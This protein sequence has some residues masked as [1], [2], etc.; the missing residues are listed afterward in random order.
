[1]DPKDCYILLKGDLWSTTVTLVNVYFPTADLSLLHYV[2]P[3]LLMEG[4]F[5]MGG[6]FN[7]FPEALLDVSRGSFHLSYSDLK[8]GLKTQLRGA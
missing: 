7:F 6:D 4:I 8:K 3:I 5:V 1:M 2:M